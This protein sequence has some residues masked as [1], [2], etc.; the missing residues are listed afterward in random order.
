MNVAIRIGPLQ[1]LQLQSFFHILINRK[2]GISKNFKPELWP[3][4]TES[5]LISVCV[6][7]YG[8]HVCPRWVQPS[9]FQRLVGL[10]LY[11]K[12]LELE[13]AVMCLVS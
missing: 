11:V 10:L 12:G 5:Y 7:N 9:L 1:R 3:N 13:L 4:R 8:L 6:P 2:S